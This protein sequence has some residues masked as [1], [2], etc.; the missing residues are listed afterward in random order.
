M[1]AA[2]AV[3]NIFRVLKGPLNSMTKYE[4]LFPC[5]YEYEYEWVEAIQ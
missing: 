4:V 3:V 1:K 5:S 2:V